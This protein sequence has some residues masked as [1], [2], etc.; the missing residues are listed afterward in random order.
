[1]VDGRV[2]PSEL[3]LK[4]ELTALGK[5]RFLRDP[6]TCSSWRSHLSSKSFLATSDVVNHNGVAS[7]LSQKHTRQA[8]SEKKRKTVYL[9]N[10]RHHSNKSSESRVKL[11]ADERQASAD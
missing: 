8:E 4:K 9:Y 10:W 5:A 6:E 2:G 7:S 11:G 1:M 3:H